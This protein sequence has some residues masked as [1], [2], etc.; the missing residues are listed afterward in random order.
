MKLNEIVI[1]FQSFRQPAGLLDSYFISVPKGTLWQKDLKGV[2]RFKTQDAAEKA[3]FSPAGRHMR[4]NYA[5]ADHYPIYKVYGKQ[6][7]LLLQ[8]ESLAYYDIPKWFTVLAYGPTE[9]STRAAAEKAVASIKQESDIDFKE[10]WVYK[11]YN[12]DTTIFDT[13]EDEME[14]EK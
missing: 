8:I 11:T 3:L 14:I 4:D 6:E 9:K 5:A 1:N 12:L 10:V 13:P 7:F 2:W